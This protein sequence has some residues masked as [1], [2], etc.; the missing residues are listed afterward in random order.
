MKKASR[1]SR[2]KQQRACTARRAG[3]ENARG[4]TGETESPNSFEVR[5]AH[6]LLRD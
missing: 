6:Y 2:D 5:A 3:E 4:A 1:R